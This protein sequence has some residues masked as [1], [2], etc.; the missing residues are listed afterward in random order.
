MINNSI[1]EELNTKITLVLEK[2][3]ALKEE[4]QRLKKTLNSSS[5][6]EA[7]LRQEILKLKEDDEMRD[8][9]L[10]DIASRISQ[11]IGQHFEPAKM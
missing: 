2:Y 10:E 7:I 1:L 6:T 11:S 8:L 4:N 9:E 5:E 3:D